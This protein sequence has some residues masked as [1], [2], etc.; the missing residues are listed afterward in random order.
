MF[1]TSHLTNN[2]DTL[3]MMLDI[4]LTATLIAG[5][6]KGINTLTDRMQ[7]MVSGKEASDKEAGKS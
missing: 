2:Q 3:V 1:D 4:L 6:S 5:G 7:K